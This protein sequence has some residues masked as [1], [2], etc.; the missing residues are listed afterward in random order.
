M[1]GPNAARS[2][3]REVFGLFLAAM[4]NGASAMGERRISHA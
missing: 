3:E 1:V 2:Q 4:M